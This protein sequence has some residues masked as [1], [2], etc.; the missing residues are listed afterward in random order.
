MGKSDEWN[1]IGIGS[2]SL[3]NSLEFQIWFPYQD[4]QIQR[5]ESIQAKFVKF[6][7][8]QQRSKGVLTSVD[9]QCRSLDLWK[10]KDRYTYPQLC[11]LFKVMN[12]LIVSPEILQMINFNIP[13]ARLRNNRLIAFPHSNKIMLWCP[14]NIV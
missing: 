5:L 6:I 3:W 12:N 9:E 8:Y 2:T 1:A 10:L 11:F 7:V 13:K 4:F 14:Q